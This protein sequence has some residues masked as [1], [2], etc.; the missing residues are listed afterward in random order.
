ME[1]D[2]GHAAC[3]DDSTRRCPR[4]RST[5][6]A[7][8]RIAA[9]ARI[10]GSRRHPVIRIWRYSSGEG[11]MAKPWINS[12]EFKR[13]ALHAFLLVAAV[14]VLMMVFTD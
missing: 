5:L 12:P 3:R 4:A 10:N 11:S 7:G 13:G 2:D 1:T 9:D 8:E 14:F 6:T